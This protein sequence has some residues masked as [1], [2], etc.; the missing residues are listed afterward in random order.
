MNF[1]IT[2]YD[3]PDCLERRLSVRQAHLDN[4]NRIASHLLCCG[5]M[6]D[7]EGNMRGSALMVEFDSRE[8][9]D[10]FLETEPYVMAKVWEKVTVERMK[11]VFFDRQKVGN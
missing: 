4:L 10:Q 11:V 6:L 9:L 7:E 5:P 8:E 2:A 1:V 3:A